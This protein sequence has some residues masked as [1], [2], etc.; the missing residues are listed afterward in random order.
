[1]KYCLQKKKET[2]LYIIKNIIIIIV[3]ILYAKKKTS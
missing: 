2:N 1:M 3:K